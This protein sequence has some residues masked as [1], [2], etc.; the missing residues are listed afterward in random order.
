MKPSGPLG[1]FCGVV[2]W[3]AAPGRRRGRSIGDRHPSRHFKDRPLLAESS[4]RVR[5]MS[6]RR[7]GPWMLGPVLFGFLPLLGFIRG[8]QL[9]PIWEGP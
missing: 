9:R 8:A 6:L 4:R 1:P 7:A 2:S 3:G 5:E